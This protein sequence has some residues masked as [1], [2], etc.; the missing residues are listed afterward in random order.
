LDDDKELAEIGEQYSQGK[1][2]SG[3]V[4]KKL[5]K[6]IQDFVKDHQ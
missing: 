1:I 4:K 2:L 3:Q 5:I 6:V